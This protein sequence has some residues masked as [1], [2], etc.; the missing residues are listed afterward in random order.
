M[1]LVVIGV[2]Y[3][4]DHQWPAALSVQ[5]SDLLQQDQL[6]HILRKSQHLPGT[7][8]GESNGAKALILTGSQ[9]VFKSPF[10]SL[11]RYEGEEDSV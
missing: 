2:H 3:N 6:C 8:H 5:P 11:G 9:N 7:E 10:Q 4:A 1:C